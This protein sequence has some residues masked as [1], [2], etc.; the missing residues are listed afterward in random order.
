MKVIG[1]NMNYQK[2][3]KTKNATKNA[4]N[5][6]DSDNHRTIE[7]NRT[8][9][10]IKNHKDKIVFSLMSVPSDTS[11]S[12]KI[13]ENLSKY[14]DLKIE[15]TKLWHLKIIKLPVVNGELGMVAKTV[16]N[17]V[18]QIL[19][20]VLSIQ[21][22]LNTKYIPYTSKLTSN[23]SHAWGSWVRLGMDCGKN[24]KDKK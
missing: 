2:S 19:R 22:F 16:P 11:V 7:A 14:K 17:Y 8:D 15:V 13:F 6:W 21:F 20:K 1:G 5:L 24:T 3:S 23:L 9:I 18:S 12:L 10:V 4:T